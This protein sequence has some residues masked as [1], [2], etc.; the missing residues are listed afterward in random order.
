MKKIT[1]FLFVAV[2]FL[3]TGIT[4]AQS[5]V[6]GT[7][8]D[9]EMNAPLPGANIIEEGTTNGV[10]S[11]FDGEFT[12]TT[13]S[14]N[15][16]LVISY[17]GYAT[18]TVTVTGSKNIGNIVLASDNSLEE[19]V[20]VGSG[21]I[22]LAEDRA[23]PV[24]V[25]TIRASQ[26]Q[27]KA[28][29][30]DL[31]ALLKTTPSIQVVQNGGFGESQ[32][33]L[34]GFDQTNT[35]F[36][37]NGQP[38][39]GMED[40]KMYWSNWQ[41]VTEVANAIQV[42]RGLGASKLAISSVGGTVNIV[43]KTIDK[44]EGGFVEQMVG[45]DNYI[46]STAYFST[47]VS[48]KGWSFSGLLGHWQGDGYVDNTQGQGQTYFLSV[49]YQAGENHSLN[50]LLTGAPQWHAVAGGARISDFLESD[51]GRRYNSWNFDGVDSPN[52]LHGG[53]YPGGRNIYHKPVANLNWD[54]TINDKS[55]LSTVLYGSM[56]RGSFAQAIDNDRNNV[57][58][59]VRGSNNNHN[60][61]GLVTSYNNQLTES[62]NLNIG[63]DVRLYNGFHFRDVR[64]F[65]NPSIN[66][67]EA[68]SGYSGGNDYYL[69]EA[70]GINPWEVFVNPNTDHAQRFGYDYE[71]QINYAGVF[72][73]LEYAKD[74]FSAFFQGALS[75][76]SHVRT[77]FL[78]TS[79]PGQG[80]E[81]DKVNNIGYNLKAGAAYELNNM[82]KVF[83]NV[84]YYS[85]QPFHDNLYQNDRGGNELLQ[86]ETENEE[87]TGFEVGYQFNGGRRISANLNAYHTT[88]DNRTLIRGNNENGDDFESIQIFGVKEVHYGVELEVMT[89]PLDNLR[90]NG[91]I[92]M[93]EWQ[94]K[95]NATQRVFNNDGVQ[96]VDDEE[97]VI[98]GF[99][100]GQAAQ[101]TAG[102]NGSY[103]FLPRTS[104]DAA[105]S[106][107]NDMFSSGAL[108][109][110]PLSLPSYDTVDAGFSYK[111]LVGKNKQKSIQFRLNVN[112]VFD[113]VYLEAVFGNEA[114][115][116][117]DG[118]YKGINTSNNGRFGYGRTW[119]TSI[120]FN[121]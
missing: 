98:D 14:T 47:G 27:E 85:R 103:E 99:S 80:E 88:W 68:D 69:T 36:L 107:N 21:V 116:D 77:E 72:G 120:R 90:L 9:A 61:A 3:F 7:I 19:I 100:V 1:R 13:E 12:I 33:F 82:H 108:N 96:I 20:I 105:W 32:M 56:G 109:K 41:G 11:N 121:F 50:F 76:Q 57:L 73:Q 84:G 67:V 10:S 46:K 79:T 39:N 34:R 44:K 93:G 113:E 65:V 17:V 4:M 54:W 106:W 26:I 74:G 64:E 59:Y 62:L 75:N 110:A 111:M 66:S 115:N 104:F 37:L 112:N 89:R 8:M 2:A 71:E 5:T 53:A 28:G 63:A 30:F 51:R 58:E 43:T 55:S 91:F 101:V 38:I 114:V 87:I 117:V 23:T 97:I 16:T 102:I 52:T 86:P 35:A 78:N 60:W 119:N 94:Y 31:P 48:D 95:D 118:N 92:S 49:G 83:A 24:A 6:I 45:N 29:N 81:G 18:Q 70:G 25:S 40:G 22:D 42:Q 15:A